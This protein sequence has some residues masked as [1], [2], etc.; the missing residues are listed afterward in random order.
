MSNNIDKKVVDDFGNEW[1]RFQQADITYDAWNQ[2]FHIFPFS[3]INNDSVGFDMGC[4]SGRWA[5]FMYDKVGLLNCVDPSKKALNV[6]KK[7]LQAASNINFIEASVGDNNILQEGSQDFGYC[8]GVLHHVPETAEGIKSCSKLLKKGAPFL[9]YLYYNFENKPLF[10]KYL[11]KASDIIRRII[12]RLP[13]P[14]KIIIA[15]LIA[16][17]VYLPLAKLSNFVEKLGL[18]VSNIPLSDY[19]DKTLHFIRTD[20]LDR[21]GTRLEQRFDKA[22]IS[23]MLKNAG[24]EQPIFSESTPH[25]VALTRKV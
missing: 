10:Y 20:S 9:I 17:L 12:S 4:G 5:T 7:N 21:F 15:E 1:D 11:W 13:N 2:Y 19:R 25:W 8:L 14:L 22:E 3:E 6:A 23:N 16:I 18:N 24:F